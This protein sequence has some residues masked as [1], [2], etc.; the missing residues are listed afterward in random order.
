[1]NFDGHYDKGIL[2]SGSGC[3]AILDSGSWPCGADRVRVAQTQYEYSRLLVASV[4]SHTFGFCNPLQSLCG[5]RGC[6]PQGGVP[7]S[8]C[9]SVLAATAAPPVLGE[10]RCELRDRCRSG[11]VGDRSG[12]CESWAWSPQGAKARDVGKGGG[13]GGVVRVQ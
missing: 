6:A 1:V 3:D 7:V 2:G 9:G 12:G 4:L 10:E 13:A 5:V 11:C 8:S